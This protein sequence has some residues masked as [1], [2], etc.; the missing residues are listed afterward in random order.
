MTISKQKMEAALARMPREL[1]AK[2]LNMEF[3]PHFLGKNKFAYRQERFDAQG[4]KTADWM[5]YD[6]KEG[7]QTVL[8]EGEKLSASLE[9]ALGRP[10][11]MVTEELTILGLEE[12]GFKFR[13]ADGA[14]YTVHSGRLAKQHSA[15]PQGAVLSPDGSRALYTKE[16]DLYLRDVAAGRNH[17]LTQDGTPE[18]GYGIGDLSFGGQASACGVLW[19]PDNR[20]F[21]TCRTDY[22]GVRRLELGEQSWPCALAGDETLPVSSWILGDAETMT[23]KTLNTDPFLGYP[24]GD[25]PW[26]AWSEEGGLALVC[27]LSRDFTDLKAWKVPA[28][29]GKAE[30]L[31]VEHDDK[32]ICGDVNR[33]FYNRGMTGKCQAPALFSEKLGHLY[34]LSMRS[35]DNQVWRYDLRNGSCK[36]MT[37]GKFQVCQLIDLDTKGRKLYLTIAGK[38][39]NTNPDHR[40]F[41][42]LELQK[43][44]LELLSRTKGDNQIHISPDRDWFL[45]CVSSYDTPQETALHEMDGEIRFPVCFGNIDK[46]EEDRFVFPIPLHEKGADG[47]TEIRGMM[48][49]PVGFDGDKE[50]PVVDLYYGAPQK[51]V[52]PVRFADTLK[53][54]SQVLSALGF[55]S[56][57]IDGRGTPGRGR[58]FLDYTYNAMGACGLADHVALLIRLLEQ[59]P[60]LD[61]EKVGVYGHSAGGFAA[62]HCLADAPEVYKAAVAGAPLCDLGAVERSWSE[63]YMGKYDAGTWAA[64]NPNLDNIKGRLLLAWGD[65]DV[66][67]HP[68]L[69]GGKTAAALQDKEIPHSTLVLEGVGHSLH[70]EARYCEAAAKFLADALL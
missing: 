42:E 52:T 38:E 12:T 62:L 26:C 59:Y 66:K 1:A 51:A 24:M 2:T 57:I 31:F 65:R 44:K 69:H 21:I 5:L 17:R 40:Y 14:V 64:Q 28:D 47:K 54:Y 8:A 9:K 67:V 15:L 25:A 18:N 20:H 41:Y 46:L 32:F 23:L 55:V 11:D 48:F 45:A 70:H 13:L 49:M 19:S 30:I 50:Y 33:E 10:V 16:G 22:T 37:D 43:G 53:N 60:F 61:R 58:K 39:G 7:G 34:W 6:A 35:G 68:D 4:V 36:K 29:S 56:V 27:T 3:K 63:R